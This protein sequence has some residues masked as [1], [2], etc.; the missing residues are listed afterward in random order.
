MNSLNVNPARK[1]QNFYELLSPRELGRGAA[2]K[3]DLSVHVVTSTPLGIAVSGALVI[4]RPGVIIAFLDLCFDQLD[5]FQISWSEANGHTYIYYYNGLLADYEILDI[6]IN[7]KQPILTHDYLLDGTNT[8]LAYLK[9]SKPTYRLQ[10]ERFSI[11]Y[12]WADEVANAI[13]AFGYGLKTNSI[14]LILN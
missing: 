13:T 3:K 2:A 5:R 1:F 8:V 4:P 11:E 14:Q 10:A 12:V 6:G 7:A 9:D